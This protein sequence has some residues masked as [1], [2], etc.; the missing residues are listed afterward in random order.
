[1]SGFTPNPYGMGGPMMPTAPRSRHY[2]GRTYVYN[3]PVYQLSPTGAYV[4]IGTYQGETRAYTIEKAFQN[5]TMR[6][7]REL[8]DMV[9]FCVLD[10]RYITQKW[11]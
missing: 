1:M 10:N 2:R 4:Q 9:G 8:G 3:G 7:R 11:I 6:C 5:L